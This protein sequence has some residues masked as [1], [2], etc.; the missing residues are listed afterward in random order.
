MDHFLASRK[1]YLAHQKWVFFFVWVFCCSCF[2]GVSDFVLL[3]I[4]IFFFCKSLNLSLEM[5]KR[6][7][8]KIYISSVS[9][10]ISSG[11][12]R[13][14]SYIW[15]WQASHLYWKHSSVSHFLLT[16]AVWRPVKSASW[17]QSFLGWILSFP[18]TSCVILS[19]FHRFHIYKIR[20]TKIDTTLISERLWQCMKSIQVISWH[21]LSKCSI[22]ISYYFSSYYSLLVIFFPIGKNISLYSCFSQK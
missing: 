13:T 22:K 21:L 17:S 1:F 6:Y 9:S 16:N 10:K 2:S 18:C 14:K 20:I 15:G 12:M 8:K 3:V 7:T 4:I 19:E 5:R 11:N